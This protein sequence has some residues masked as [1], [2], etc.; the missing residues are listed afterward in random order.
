MLALAAGSVVVAWRLRRKL[1]WL[2]APV[3][4]LVAV[5]APRL[6]RRFHDALWS[7]SGL[8]VRFF[9][10]ELQP[11]P[12]AHMRIESWTTA[13]D[14]IA[15]HPVLGVG[16]NNYGL[17]LAARQDPAAPLAGADASLLF[18]AA[19]AGLLGLGLLVG[20]LAAAHRAALAGH[21]SEDPAVRARSAGL[22]GMLAALL[23]ATVFTNGLLYPPVV[24]MLWFV[25]TAAAARPAAVR[26]PSV[27]PG[28]DAAA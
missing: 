27:Q 8:V 13:F 11:E 28:L 21:V 25:A 1:L 23:V 16:F 6:A 22:E 2:A 14:V 17:E 9:G 15:A 26:Q 3:V 12:S 19:T 18:V 20:L 10:L 4:P 5:T 7:D 24:V